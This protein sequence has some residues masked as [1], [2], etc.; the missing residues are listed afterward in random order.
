LSSSLAA[1][2]PSWALAGASLALIVPN[3]Q[4]IVAD[5]HTPQTR[6]RAFGMM[7]L[8]ASAGGMIGALLATNI[9]GIIFFNESV[10]K[11][12]KTTH[13]YT[14]NLS[15]KYVASWSKFG[16]V[17]GWRLAF[18]GAGTAAAAVGMLNFAVAEDPRFI[19]NRRNSTETPKTCVKAWESLINEMSALLH[20]PSFTLTVVQGKKERRRTHRIPKV[21]SVLFPLFGVL[22]IKY[23]T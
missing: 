20:V 4:S 1:A 17:E 7:H 19:D 5:Y 21:F 14:N 18:V 9:G 10:F 15:Y 2:L 13:S 8:S 22:C 6:G 12:K 23:L 3:A 11:G 16:H